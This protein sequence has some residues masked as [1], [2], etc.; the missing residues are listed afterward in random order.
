MR[1]NEAE[2]QKRLS[3]IGSPKSP[4]IVNEKEIRDHFQ[5]CLK[6]YAENVSLLFRHEYKGNVY[7][8]FGFL[9]NKLKKCVEFKNH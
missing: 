9:E 5:I 8:I 3:S 2:I 7:G 4:Q 6:M 1:R